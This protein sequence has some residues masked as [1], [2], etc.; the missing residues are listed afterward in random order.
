MNHTEASKTVGDYR[1]LVCSCVNRAGKR[2]GVLSYADADDLIQDA[3]VHLI[4]YSLPKYD[5][6]I[7]VRSF[8]YAMTDRYVRKALSR[9]RTFVSYDVTEAGYDKESGEM[10]GHVAVSDV[11]GPELAAAAAIECK[12]VQDALA[13]LTEVEQALVEAMALGTCREYR[14]E[15]GLTPVQMTR[16]KARVRAKLA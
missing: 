12:R 10:T 2:F 3:C 4:T 15:H 11:S 1:E 6:R 16:A 7:S 5:G 9:R 13:R 14:V 8:I